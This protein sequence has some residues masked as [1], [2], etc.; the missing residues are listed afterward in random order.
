MPR[1]QVSGVDPGRCLLFASRGLQIVCVLTALEYDVL[2]S[3][4][5]LQ[6]DAARC[7]VVF[8]AQERGGAGGDAHLAR[9]LHHLESKKGSGSMPLR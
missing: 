4:Q 8:L 1:R 3:P 9:G 2:Q 5:V 6:V 7:R